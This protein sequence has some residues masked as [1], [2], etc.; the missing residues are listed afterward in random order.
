L[1]GDRLSDMRLY[2]SYARGSQNV[3]SDI[4]ILILL[5]MDSLE[6]RKHL[7][8]ICE[9]AF[10]IDLNHGVILSPVVRS[11]NDYD[12]RKELPGFYNNVMREGVS[13]VVG[14]SIS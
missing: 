9:I 1:F 2:G 11:K 3:D 8:K 13:I 12:E 14:G 10:E 6:A 4:D 7:G 5:D